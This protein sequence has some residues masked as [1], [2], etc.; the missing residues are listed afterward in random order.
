[1]IYLMVLRRGGVPDVIRSI[2]LRRGSV[3]VALLCEQITRKER[4]WGDIFCNFLIK[5]YGEKRSRE[6]L[7]ITISP[8]SRVCVGM[9]QII[10]DK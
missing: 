2:Q 5:E 3:S 6:C 4:I 8:M 9:T 10:G 7:L 1:M